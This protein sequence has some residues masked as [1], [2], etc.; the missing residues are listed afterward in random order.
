MTTMRRH[1][2]RSASTAT[3]HAWPDRP[4]S[5]VLTV[6]LTWLLPESVRYLALWGGRDARIAAIL[7][8]V[9]PDPALAGARF[10]GV[11]KASGSPVRQLFAPGLVAGTVL[12]WLCF[13]MSLLVF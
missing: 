2:H 4:V 7:G 9:R 13:F 6:A 5:S 3:R 12:L 1:G 8:R 11:R 10:V